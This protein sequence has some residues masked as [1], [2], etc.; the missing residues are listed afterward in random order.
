MSKFYILLRNSVI[1]G[2]IFNISTKSFAET[3]C[4]EPKYSETVPNW[5]VDFKFFETLVD[6]YLKV[7]QKA[8]S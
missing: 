8:L 2:K 6:Q 7:I 4:S 5:R 3:V 1:F